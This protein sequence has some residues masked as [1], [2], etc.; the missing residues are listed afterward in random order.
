MV[1]EIG[2]WGV[3]GRERETGEGHASQAHHGSLTAGNAA[4]LALRADP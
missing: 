1:N 2:D 4:A 3:H